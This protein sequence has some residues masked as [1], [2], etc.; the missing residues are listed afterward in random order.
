MRMRGRNTTIGKRKGS[1][2]L[3]DP[4]S[5]YGRKL[6]GAFEAE[7]GPEPE[8]PDQGSEGSKPGSGRID[9]STLGA[10][11]RLLGVSPAELL[12]GA[13]GE[14][15]EPDPPWP[16]E[17]NTQ[18]LLRLCR[19]FRSPRLRQRAKDFVLTRRIDL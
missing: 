17:S 11:A 18:R 15:A 19:S 12:S 5:P 6:R 7:R 8:T 1:S 10:V 14:P 3:S 4:D 13:Q 2:R 9:A 16:R